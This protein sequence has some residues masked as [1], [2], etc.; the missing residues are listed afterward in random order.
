QI[1]KLK[2]I[3]KNLSLKSTNGLFTIVDYRDASGL[4]RNF[5]VALLEYFDQVGFTSR[6]GDYR[7]IRLYTKPNQKVESSN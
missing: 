1:N 3:A 2:A 6:T 7:E 5:A 4:S